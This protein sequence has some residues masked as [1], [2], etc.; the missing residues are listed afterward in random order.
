MLTAKFVA[1][2]GALLWG[3]HNAATGKCFPSYETIAEKAECARST[4][5]EAI[6]ALEDAGILSWVNRIARI[7]EWW[8][9][10]LFGKPQPRWRVIRTSNAYAFV[11]PGARKAEEISR[12]SSKSDF[13]TGT[14]IQESKKE[15]GKFRAA[16]DAL[17]RG[18]E[19]GQGV[20]FDSFDAALALS[21]ER[22]AAKSGAKGLAK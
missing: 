15:S 19:A 7:R 21:Q 12:F 17:G 2:L 11:D 20:L 9:A 1:V 13:P 10:D 14:A 22:R 16:L 6:R 4:V 5:Y 18:T 8:G 3:F